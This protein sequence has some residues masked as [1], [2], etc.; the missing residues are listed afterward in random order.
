MPVGYG[1]ENGTESSGAYLMTK[2][3]NYA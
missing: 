1:S 2:F 3:A